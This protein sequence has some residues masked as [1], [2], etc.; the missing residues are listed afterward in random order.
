[1]KNKKIVINKNINFIQAYA[2]KLL[3]N[4]SSTHGLKRA[5]RMLLKEINLYKNHIY[6]SYVLKNILK[7]YRVLPKKIQIGGGRH[8]LNGFLNIDINSPADI[9]F[10]VREGLPLKS[11]YAELIFSEHFLEHID[12]PVSVKKFIRECYRVLDKNG[13]LIIG[14]PDSELLI[15]NYVKKNKFF[16][17]YII[18]RWYLKRKCLK[19]FNTYID[20][21][22]YHFRDQDDD[23]EY[24]P[25][26]WAYDFEKLKSLF[27]CAGFNKIKKWKFEPH[28]ANPKRQWAS[29]YVVG[30]K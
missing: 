23:R 29:L 18:N 7:K 26:Y 4:K 8:I 17:R 21:V 20:L 11:N 2:S 12:Y 30:V 1:M 15:K 10:D 5:L 24:N 27:Q 6:G 9:V 25:H 13:K 14:V 19:H 16:W 3:E 28:I 22:N